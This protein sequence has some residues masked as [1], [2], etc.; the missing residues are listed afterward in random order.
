MK[1]PFRI[2][3]RDGE[4]S[5]R[6]TQ[7]MGVLNVTP[8]SFS[9]GGA[10]Y[11][12]AL[13]VARGLALE[14]EG[15]LILDVGGESTRPGSLPVSAAEE[16]RRVVPVIERLAQEP[17]VRRGRVWISVDT[18]KAAVASE[19]LAAGAH[20]VNDI[21]ALRDPAM[22]EVVVQARAGLVLMHMRGT[23]ADM[24]QNPEYGDVVSDVTSYLLARARFAE[25]AELARESIL[26][27]PGI[28]FGK[29]VEHNLKLLAGLPR[30]VAS[31]YPV[32]LG[33]SRKSFIGK[34][35]GRGVDHRLAGTLATVA[36][37]VRQDVALVRV[38][39]V[40]PAVDVIRMTEAIE[41]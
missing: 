21:S 25:E 26:I 5:F 7:V 32:V 20:L 14:A 38:H 24:Q 10:F 16:I 35:L 12:P 27:D 34:L 11:D 17:S 9:D 30:L 39:D 15:A 40:A 2:P 28:G 36:W 29:T 13:A 19:A 4:I 1:R 41:D 8:D 18:C 6:G 37:A 3:V 31:G 22:P 33:T 23:P